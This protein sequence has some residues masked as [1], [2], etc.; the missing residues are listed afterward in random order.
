M[1]WSY[2]QLVATGVSAGAV[3]DGGCGL[4]GRRDG[5]M[6]DSPLPITKLN[7]GSYRFRVTVEASTCTANA[8]SESASRT[9]TIHVARSAHLMGCGRLCP[10]GFRGRG[11]ARSLAGARPTP[12]A[13]TFKARF[14]GAESVIDEQLGCPA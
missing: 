1:S 8:R 3:G 14:A 11:A 9:F 6:Y 5:Q 2:R 12:Y 10:F 7:A 13:S 4:A